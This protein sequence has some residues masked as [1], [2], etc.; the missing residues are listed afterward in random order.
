MV[1]VLVY[2][3]S[4]GELL[5]EDEEKLISKWEPVVGD[6]FDIVVRNFF[7]TLGCNKANKI[8]LRLR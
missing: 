7:V 2:M 8:M 5:G 6:A 1:R 3:C 4:G